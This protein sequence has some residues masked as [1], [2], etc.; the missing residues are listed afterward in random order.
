[1]TSLRS[2]GLSTEKIGNTRKRGNGRGEGGSSGITEREREWNRSR[3]RQRQRYRR[4]SDFGYETDQRRRNGE[5][6]LGKG[7]IEEDALELAD[8]SDV[9]AE[10]RSSTASLL[11]HNCEIVSESRLECHGAEGAMVG[12][13]AEYVDSVES[14]VGTYECKNEAHDSTAL[15]RNQEVQGAREALE[16]DVHS[17]NRS[18][19]DRT[20]PVRR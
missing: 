20:R 12:A 19:M 15:T 3:N 8:G 18:I 7:Y 13:V 6:F 17:N 10:A 14:F 9:G 11:Q 5:T 4:R 16:G 1:M 2:S